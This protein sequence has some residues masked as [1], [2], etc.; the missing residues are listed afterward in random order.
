MSQQNME[1]EAANI[2]IIFHCL[3]QFAYLYQLVDLSLSTTKNY[4]I[5]PSLI[6]S[7]EPKV[8][9]FVLWSHYS[10]EQDHKSK[11]KSTVICERTAYLLTLLKIPSLFSAKS[12]NQNTFQFNVNFHLIIQAIYA[13]FGIVTGRYIC[14]IDQSRSCYC[15]Q[16][17]R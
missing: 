16:C 8:I 11:D 3:V 12:T 2:F 14:S 17:P 5:I 10:F 1:W 7:L 9:F 4:E 6:I 13:Y 15:Y